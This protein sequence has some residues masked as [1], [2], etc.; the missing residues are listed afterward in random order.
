MKYRYF[1]APIEEVRN[2]FIQNYGK[3]QIKS[4]ETQDEF[5]EIVMDPNYHE[6]V[7]FDSFL[8]F[9]ILTENNIY[10]LPKLEKYFKYIVFCGDNLEELNKRIKNKK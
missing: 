6:A 4:A 1:Q 5:L 2:Q 9:D 7:I 3:S 10:H 8:F